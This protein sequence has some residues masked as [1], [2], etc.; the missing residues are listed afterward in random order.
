MLHYFE[1]VTLS[2]SRASNYTLRTIM[3][4]LNA[5]Y[6]TD[7]AFD[8]LGWTQPFVW[9]AL[10]WDRVEHVAVVP[11]SKKCKLISR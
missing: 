6:L 9:K 7:A 8:V 2:Q 10:G 5:A 11:N 3:R 4:T 1:H